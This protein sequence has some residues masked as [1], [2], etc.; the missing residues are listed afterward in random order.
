MKPFLFFIFVSF[1]LFSESLWNDVAADIYCKN[2]SYKEGDTIEIILEENS[3]IDYKSSSKTSKSLNITLQGGET[4][5]VLDFLPEGGVDENKNSAI[6]D[7]F[8]ISNSIQGA[9]SAVNGQTVTISATK[10]LTLN[11]KISSIQITGEANFS[12]IKGKKISSK[13]LLNSQIS[14]ISLSDNKNIVLNSDDFEKY[15]LNPDSTT[16]LREDTRIRDDKK[17]Q[18]LLDYF[19]KI[20]NVVF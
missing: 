2:V 3:Q 4:T 14:I 5:S 12:D 6:K 15:R 7:S 17:R 19:N 18:I 8:K 20:L 9:I 16:D 11:N 10:N 13:K 1:T